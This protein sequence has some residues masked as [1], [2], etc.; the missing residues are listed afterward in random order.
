MGGGRLVVGLRGFATRSICGD[1]SPLTKKAV[2]RQPTELQMWNRWRLLTL[3]LAACAGSTR[4]ISDTG[5]Q[6]W[7]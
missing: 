5:K 3:P 2:I 4:S 7:T 1:G 6:S